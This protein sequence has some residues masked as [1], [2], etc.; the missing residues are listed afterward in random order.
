MDPIKLPSG[1]ELQITLS[2]FEVS[3]DLF[4]AFLE[5][6]KL[7]KIDPQADIDINLFKDL[8]CYGFS[9]KKIET[10]LYKCFEKSLYNKFKITKE[11]FEPEDVRQDYLSVCIEVAKANIMPFTKSLSAEYSV[12]FEMLMK[13]DHA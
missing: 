8:F 5:E 6:M 2:P 1:A 4:K 7:L 13:K 3:N 11:T 10:C 12:I 9:S